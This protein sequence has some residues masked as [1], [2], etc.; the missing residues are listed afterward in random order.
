MDSVKIGERIRNARNRLNLTQ[1]QLGQLVDKDQNTIS[2]YE[3]GK[4]R[5]FAD[6]IPKFASALE[7]SVSYF[8][9]DESPQTEIQDEVLIQINMLPDEDARMA[10]LDLLRLLRKTLQDRN[11]P[12][13]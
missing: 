12:R 1:E 5:I 6:E 8:F 11:L 2:K 10:A 3:M 7:V 4:H 13:S 9:E